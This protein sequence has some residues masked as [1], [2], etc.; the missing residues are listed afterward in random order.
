[1]GG[2]AQG[3]VASANVV[4]AFRRWA[5]ESLPEL[6]QSE[7]D[8]ES[9]RVDWER[10]I[11]D[12]NASIREYGMQLGARM[13]TTAVVMLLTQQRYYI[14]NV[15]DSRAYEL[16][17]GLRQIT[18]DHSYVAR[19]VALGNI[20]PEDAEHHPKR[21]VLLQCVGASERVYPDMF[22][23]DVQPGTVYMLCSDG[24]RHEI[25]PQEI[26]E[27]LQPVRMTDE[28]TMRRSAWELVELNKQRRERDNISVAL[29]KTL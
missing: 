18:N 2:L 11:Q 17:A 25:T 1:M 19:E 29:I 14:M 24:F 7:L 12:Q 3:E 28:E 6:C 23:G 21:N 27:K 22:F 4:R 8:E 5:L 26:Y 16:R 15:G 10:I 9:I 20:R 13:G